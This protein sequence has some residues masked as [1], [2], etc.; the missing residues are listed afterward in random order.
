MLYDF[1][2]L[3]ADGILISQKLEFHKWYFFFISLVSFFS[4]SFLPLPFFPYL[5]SPFLRSQL[6]GVLNKEL[7]VCV[8]R[9][10]WQCNDF[11]F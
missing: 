8:K 3:V 4:F 1:C 10:A 2:L 6:Y 11:G 5:P 9:I 7:A